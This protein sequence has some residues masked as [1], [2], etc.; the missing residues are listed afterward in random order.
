VVLFISYCL[1]EKKSLLCVAA[2]LDVT[3]VTCCM[4]AGNFFVAV[5]IKYQA[6]V[7]RLWI[8]ILTAMQRLAGVGEKRTDLI[9]LRENN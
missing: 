2:L 7:K 9:Q 3:R 4:P 8:L 5:E 6:C 1:C